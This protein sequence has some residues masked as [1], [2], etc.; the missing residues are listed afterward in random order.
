M[1]Q[2]ALHVGIDVAKD[3]LDV[4]ILETGELFAVDNDEAG[5]AALVER[6]S[7]CE[8]DAIGLEAS[9][10]YERAVLKALWQKGLPVRRI[11]PHRLR[12]FA[13]AAGV[14]AKND[15]L[16]ARVIARFLATLPVRPVEFDPSL[17]L[18]IELVTVRR[19]LHAELS[20]VNNQLEHVRDAALKRLAKRRASRLRA[21]ILLLDKSIAQAIAA[22]PAMAHRNSL[23]RSTPSVGPVL[24]ATLIALLPELG[25]L[26]NRRIAALVGLAPFDH[27]SGKLKGKRCIWGGREPV[28]NVLYMAALSAGVHNPV[29]AAFRQRLRAKGKVAKVAIVAVMRKLIT[30]LN[31]MIRDDKPW[32]PASV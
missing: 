15:R 29:F 23:L 21:D 11:N 13:R 9:G 14:N 28:R 31:A 7:G 30:T 1:T 4:A 18:V 17:E 25:R 10:G 12:Q 26:S 6:L 19:Q 2:I 3:R 32:D 8:L 22:D 24:S 5:H 20:R 16:D 27:D